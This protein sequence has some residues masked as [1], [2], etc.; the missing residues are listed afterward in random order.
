MRKIDPIPGKWPDY[1]V[2]M[3]CLL[4]FL[5]GPAL[6]GHAQGFGNE[7]VDYDKLFRAGLKR[8]GKFLNLSGRKIGDE[9]VKRLIDSGVLSKVQKADLR[10]N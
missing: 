6:P 7:S 3:G 9:G 5:L 1:L 4:A 10:Y 2:L 8:G